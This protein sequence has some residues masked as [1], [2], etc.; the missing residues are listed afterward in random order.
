MEGQN[1]TTIN[2]GERPPSGPEQRRGSPRASPRVGEAK[3]SL[4]EPRREPRQTRILYLSCHKNSSSHRIIFMAFK[5]LKLCRF[6]HINISMASLGLICTIRS[7]TPSLDRFPF[8]RFA[9]WGPRVS[10]PQMRPLDFY[11]FSI[12]LFHILFTQWMNSH[13]RRSR[14]IECSATTH[15][16]SFT[17]LQRH[18]KKRRLVLL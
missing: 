12:F 5:T 2:G 4:G 11:L 13:S 10:R 7:L 8:G 6:N 15:S 9:S 1:S 18:W 14:L 16:P 3:T 17:W